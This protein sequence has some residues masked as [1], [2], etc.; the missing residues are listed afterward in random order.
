VWEAER[1]MEA[2]VFERPVIG[3]AVVQAADR[4]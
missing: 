2:A 3:A 4:E 1:S